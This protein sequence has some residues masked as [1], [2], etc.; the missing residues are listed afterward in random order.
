LFIL[1]NLAFVGSIGWY[2]YWFRYLD[3]DIPMKNYEDKE[4]R[5]AVIA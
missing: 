2:N 5:G 3:L 4:Y 1:D